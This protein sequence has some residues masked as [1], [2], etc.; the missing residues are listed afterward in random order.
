MPQITVLALQG[1]TCMHCVGS[2]RKALETV[3]GVTAVDVALDS[4]KVTGD[5]DPQ[6]LINAVEQ[7]GY[8]ATLA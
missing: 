1:L 3:P 2:T 4:A 5:A 7:A 6:T 8:Q